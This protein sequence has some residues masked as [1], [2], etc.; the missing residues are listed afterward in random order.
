MEA[1]GSAHQAAVALANKLARVAWAVWK[2]GREYESIAPA[3]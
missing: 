2:N 1:C 3:A